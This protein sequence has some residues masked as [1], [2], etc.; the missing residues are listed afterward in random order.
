MKF[1]AV[2]HGADP[3]DLEDKGYEVIDRKENL[4]FG[5]PADYENMTQEERNALSEKMEMKFTKWAGKSPLAPE[6]RK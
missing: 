3:K 4:L 5:D 2:L 6:K 1:N